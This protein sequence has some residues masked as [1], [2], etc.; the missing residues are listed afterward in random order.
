MMKYLSSDWFLADVARDGTYVHVK[1]RACVLQCSIVLLIA[2]EIN[3][4]LSQISVVFTDE[5]DGI[6][7]TDY[8]RRLGYVRF[9]ERQYNRELHS[10][11]TPV[12][13]LID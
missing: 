9:N 13:V 8:Q 10:V 3:R 2:V 5:E 7:G 4:D 12:A 11:C 1:I 6:D